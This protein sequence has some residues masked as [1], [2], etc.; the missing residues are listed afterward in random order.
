[1]VISLKKMKSKNVI[2]VTRVAKG[3]VANVVYNLAANMKAAGYTPS[4]VFD[5]NVRSNVR[6]ALLSSDINTIELKKERA[7]DNNEK[8]PQ[9]NRRISDSVRAL[10][11][12]QAATWYLSLKSIY[13]FLYME[14]PR[15]KKYIQ[16]I[17]LT[18]TIQ[19]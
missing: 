6:E 16:L 19:R 4:V 14:V 12:N 15:I 7:V 8:P 18:P 2:H 1:M 10:F 9:K 3:G 17:K 13:H 5:T 11:G